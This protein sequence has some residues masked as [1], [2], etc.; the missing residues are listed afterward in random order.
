MA[1]VTTERCPCEQKYVT[2]CRGAASP[3]SAS[4]MGPA[5]T[6]LPRMALPPPAMSVAGLQQEAQPDDAGEPDQADADRD[7]VEVALGDRGTAESAGDAAAEHVGQA[8]ATSLVQKHEENHE[9]AR[10]DEQDLE[11]GDHG[12]NRN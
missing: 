8:A 3:R 9:E 6:R 5:P 4:P 2:A 1:K 12:V 11:D 10:D 7:P